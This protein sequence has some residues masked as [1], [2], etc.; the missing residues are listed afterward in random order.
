MFESVSRAL[1]HCGPIYG[2]TTIPWPQLAVDATLGL[3]IGLI[4]ELPLEGNGN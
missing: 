3:N 4:A 1:P 2:P